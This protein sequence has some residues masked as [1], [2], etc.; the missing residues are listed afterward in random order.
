MF[1]AAKSYR[2]YPVIDFIDSLF[3]V[4]IFT[5]KWTIPVENREYR[6]TFDLNFS[7]ENNQWSKTISIS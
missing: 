2:F 3:S 5:L 6:Q 4:K 1:T 7:F